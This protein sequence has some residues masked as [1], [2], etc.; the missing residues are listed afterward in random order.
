MRTER[1]AGEVCYY[2]PADDRGA[3]DKDGRLDIVCVGTASANIK[4][5]ENL[6]RS[7]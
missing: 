1:R 7:R 5:Y 6:G 4:W 2:D 3:E